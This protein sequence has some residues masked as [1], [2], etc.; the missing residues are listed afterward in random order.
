MLPR[1]T[2]SVAVHESAT[3]STGL[4][5]WNVR[6]DFGTQALIPVRCGKP[7]FWS[8]GSGRL[9]VLTMNVNEQDREDDRAYALIMR[10]LDTSLGYCLMW[11]LDRLGWRS[12]TERLN[13]RTPLT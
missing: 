10:T 11:A 13:D 7:S 9:L 3:D 8:G 1:R 2:S 6:R 4:P 12:A 5:I